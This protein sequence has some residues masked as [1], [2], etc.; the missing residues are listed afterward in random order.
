MQAEIAAPDESGIVSPVENCW[1]YSFTMQFPF[2]RA[3]QLEHWTPAGP[4]FSL[5]SKLTAFVA[6][7]VILSTGVSHWM[8]NR[9]LEPTAVIREYPWRLAAGLGMS[10]IL[11][12]FLLAR[13]FSRTIL[14]IA[15]TA[16]RVSEGDLD[17][18]IDITRK[19]E[20]GRLAANFNRMIQELSEHTRQLAQAKERYRGVVEDVP[21]LICTFLPGGE[22]TFVNNTYS[23]YF[24][25]TPRELVGSNFLAWIPESER[26]TI[27][28]HLSALTVEAPSQTHEHPVIAPDGEIRW[29]RWTNRA[30]FNSRGTI[31]S[32]Q[33]IGEDV[34]ERKN[35]EAIMEAIHQGTVKATGEMFFRELTRCLAQFLNVR[36]ACVGRLLPGDEIATVA[37]WAGSDW[38]ENVQYSLEGTPCA[39][40]IQQSTCFHPTDVQALF[41]DDRLAIEMNVDSY[42]GTPLRNA[43]G[44][45]C[46][47]LSVMDVK[48]MI[49]VPLLRHVLEVFA[50]RAGSELA[51]RAAEEELQILSRAVES[52]SAVVII[53]DPAGMIE[54]VN[55]KFTETTG[56]TKQEALGSHI[57]ILVTGEIPG[58][59]FDDLKNDVASDGEWKGEIRSR[60]KDG[61]LYWDRC[62]ISCV[63]NRNGDILHYV[64]IQEDITREYMLTEQL[65]Y[66]AT[67]DPLTGLIN[68]HEFERRANRLIS[69][70]RQDKTEHALCF[71][72]LDQFKVVNDTCGHG[73]GDEMLRQLARL[74]LTIVRKHDTLA[75]LGGDEFGILMEQCSL[76]Q[77]HRVAELLQKA[78]QEYQFNWEGR[79]FRVGVSIGLVAIAGGMNNFTELLKQA[80]AAC[81]M[82]KDRGRNRIHVYHPEDIELATRHG[83]MQWVA[84]IYRA[85]EENRFCLVAQPILS[86]RGETADRYEL[87]LRMVDEE[88]R[89]A[90][91]G[92]FLPAAERYNLVSNLDR[93][94]I[95]E[96]LRLLSRNRK[97]LN[98]IHSFSINLSGQSIADEAFLDYVLDQFREANL[99]GDKICFEITE[100]AAISHL[101]KAGQFISRLKQF[102]CSFALDDFGSGVS[103]FGYLKN[104]PVDYLKIDGM[105]VRDI[106]NDPIDYAMVKAINEIGKVM[107]MQTIAEFVENDEIKGML[108][109]IG[110]DYA[111]GYGIGKP[112]PLE[113][114]LSGSES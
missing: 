79:N 30:V 61:T 50:D 37:V 91:P 6:L 17:A 58:L 98:G 69:S 81:Y 36:Y 74:L 109:A 65:N 105:F 88:G 66:Q 3:K 64:S 29:Q 48:P 112:E 25:K 62:S 55:P 73:A 33:S 18:R 72:D 113:E 42:M 59:I 87:L 57:D 82:A 67:H 10:G 39:N 99:P 63:K 84:R 71:L 20:L 78:I 15:D 80:D 27:R 13:R 60:K 31:V 90:P 35:L 96:T 52:S 85:L 19:D 111:Q 75:R 11:V 110:V 86:L 8:N 108:K 7:V 107:G 21:V 1:P 53:L 41:P 94:V 101:G 2:K 102:G 4:G 93:W 106:V 100:T 14:Q 97:F 70:L 38:V 43:A 32:Y 12:T 45:T 77:A 34:S 83:E 40:V 95:K 51:R 76:D 49:Y 89:L 5:V 9:C 56:Y 47:I 68:R 24:Q 44:H 28:D 23:D 114:L 54:Y 26:Q 22:I 92:A 16:M 104:L 46:G 103:S